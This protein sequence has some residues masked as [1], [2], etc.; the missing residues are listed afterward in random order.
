MALWNTK[1]GTNVSYCFL[2]GSDGWRGWGEQLGFILGVFCQEASLFQM[3]QEASWGRCTALLTIHAASGR[4][5]S[6]LFGQAA[7][8]GVF[9]VCSKACCCGWRERK[10]I[11]GNPWSMAKPEVMVRAT[12]ERKEYLYGRTATDSNWTG[13]QGSVYMGG[14]KVLPEIEG[15]EPSG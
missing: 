15:A 1:P 2:E 6:D 12:Q 3:K 7:W 9:V 10:K 4:E 11:Q 8:V 13:N 14:S 5:N